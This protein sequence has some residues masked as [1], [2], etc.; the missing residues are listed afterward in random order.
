M[1]SIS[2]RI[3]SQSVSSCR[4]SLPTA[5][6][7]RLPTSRH[8]SSSETFILLKHRHIGS[9][10]EIKEILR[11]AV[12]RISLPPNNLVGLPLCGSHLFSILAN[13]VSCI[14]AI[15]IS[16]G[17]MQKLKS[18]GLVKNFSLVI[19]FIP[20]AYLI[21]FFIHIYLHTGVI[22]VGGL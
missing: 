10:D 18:D 5:M 7:E 4:D 8:Q 1:T 16:K 12:Y 17:F 13:S 11:L 21:L 15:L 19:A 9:T 20:N 3:L 14:F 22:R 6:T 2:D